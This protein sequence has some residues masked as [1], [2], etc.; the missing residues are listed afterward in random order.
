M[1]EAQ[2]HQLERM[3]SHR[4]MDFKRSPEFYFRKHITKEIQNADSKSMGLGRLVHLAIL[5]PER[6]TSS[7][8]ITPTVDRRTK[9]GKS[10]FEA[11]NSS[12]TETDVMVDQE[13]YKTALAIKDSFFS[14][15]D[16][17]NG[18]EFEKIHLF[19]MNGVECKAKFDYIDD[20]YIIDLKTTQSCSDDS[21]KWSSKKFGYDLQ[22]A[23]YYNAAIAMDGKPRA[24]LIA[25]IE[26]EAP[27]L[28]NVFEVTQPML[29]HRTNEIMSLLENFKQ[30]TERGEFIDKVQVKPM[31]ISPYYFEGEQ[32]EQSL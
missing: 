11:F 28:M 17:F 29:E 13:S 7:V 14:R 6:F 2:Y 20:N 8:K 32:Y 9:E 18:G 10:A 15:V 1:T 30:R 27:Y 16:M 24:Y 25:A 19:E 31:P 23:F 4:L 12:L 5:E 22:A 26:T 3:S 21:F